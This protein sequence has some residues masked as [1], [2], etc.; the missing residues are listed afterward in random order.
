ML[1]SWIKA[2]FGG[3]LRHFVLSGPD[4]HEDADGREVKVITDD[5]RPFVHYG[6]KGD[7]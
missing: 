1:M 3:A 5:E 2:A 4:L 6:R 7:K